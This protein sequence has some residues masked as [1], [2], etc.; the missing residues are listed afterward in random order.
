[1]ATLWAIYD[2]PASMRREY[3]RDGKIICS[4]SFELI[5]DKSAQQM[6]YY[7][8]LGLIRLGEFEPNCWIGDESAI[9][10]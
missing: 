3:W 6:A 1:M 7:W 9:K 10:R 5:Y 2:N 4:I 8:I